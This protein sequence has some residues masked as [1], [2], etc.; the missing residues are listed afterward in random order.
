[1]TIEEKNGLVI[2]M[3]DD[4]MTLTNDKTVSSKVFLGKLDSIENWR[5]VEEGYELPETDDLTE[6][7]QKAAAYDILTGVSE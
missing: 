2:L 1:M 6:T 4:G 5:E 3:A 7:E